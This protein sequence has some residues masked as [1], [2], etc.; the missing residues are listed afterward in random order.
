MTKAPTCC[1][2]QDNLEDVARL[3]LTNDCGSIPVCESTESKR[4]VGVITDRDITVR[5]VAAGRE[6]RSTKVSE[7]M[8]H[9]VATV[10]ADADLA[11]AVDTMEQNQVRRA[12][13]VD[14]QG[15]LVG[16]IAQAD[17][18]RNMPEQAKE[19]VQEVSQSSVSFGHVL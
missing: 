7:V 2:P 12:P 18:A 14:Q 8:S 19:L 10:P 3:M 11:S 5:A 4:I 16:I 13:V 9:P 6:P 17:V 1:T 15:C